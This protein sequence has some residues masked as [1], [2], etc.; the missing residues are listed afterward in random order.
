MANG[1]PWM[2]IYSISY[3]KIEN[4]NFST[5]ML[6]FG[7]VHCTPS[8]SNE[9]IPKMMA[10]WKK[11]LRLQKLWFLVAVLIFGDVV[12]QT[13]WPRLH[14]S[15]DWNHPYSFHEKMDLS[16]QPSGR[17]HANQP[18]RNFEKDFNP[19][20]NWAM[21]SLDPLCLFYLVWWFLP[22]CSCKCSISPTRKKRE[23]G[24]GLE[25][26]SGILSPF[27]ST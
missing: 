6:V 22:F 19:A 27:F 25:R 24:N 23:D 21:I 3:W 10:V 11:Y 9:W 15:R 13:P 5:V 1:Q 8:K 12:L 4:G 20:L 17:F 2:K 26:K 16:C 18:H 14:A 7:G